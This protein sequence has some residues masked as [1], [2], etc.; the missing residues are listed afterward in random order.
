MD[1]TTEFGGC[2]WQPV[3]NGALSKAGLSSREFGEVPA[4]SASSTDPPR[5]GH[6]KRCACIVFYT[7]SWRGSGYLRNI[8]LIRH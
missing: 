3:Q 7:R 5:D 4:I 6:A 8:D 2:Y 1:D